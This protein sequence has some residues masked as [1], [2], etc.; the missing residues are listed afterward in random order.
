MTRS[1][2]LKSLKVGD[3]VDVCIGTYSRHRKEVTSAPDTLI[4][5]GQRRGKMSFRRRDGKLAGNRPMGHMFSIEMP[6]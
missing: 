2:W 6:K 5:V 4:T 3:S 1:D